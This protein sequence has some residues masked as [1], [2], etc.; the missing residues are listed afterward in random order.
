MTQHDNRFQFGTLTQLKF[1][2]VKDE[3]IDDM[4]QNLCADMTTFCISRPRTRLSSRG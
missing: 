4:T 3:R 1:L 2:P